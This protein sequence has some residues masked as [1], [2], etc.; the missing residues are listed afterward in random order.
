ML[1]TARGRQVICV[2]TGKGRPFSCN[3][4]LSAVNLEILKLLKLRK[5]LLK[6][7]VPC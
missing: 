5:R 6:I 4:L 7:R 3:I 2:A 1:Q